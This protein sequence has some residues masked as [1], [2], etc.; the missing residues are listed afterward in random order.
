MRVIGLTGSI[1]CGKSTI[2][3]Y[4]VSCGFPVV[5]GDQLSRDL[6]AP[7]SPVLEEI[8][9]N[10]GDRFIN[11]NGNLNRRALGQL[12]FRDEHA[13]SR[14]DAVMAPHLKRL[15]TELIEHYR[16]EGAAL[17]F[18]D[19]PLLF[20]KGYDALCDVV[21]TVWL[22]EE[23]QLSRLMARDSFS[24][25]DALR[26]IRSVMS[27]DEKARRADH[28]ID[29]SGSVR[30]TLDE[31]DRLLEA[32]LN[33]A[34]AVE[35]PPVQPV[36]A[37]EPLRRSAPVPVPA[38]PRQPDVPP[39]APEVMER[40]AA[41]RRQ[42]SSRKAE[43]KNPLWMKISLIAASV[44]LA[45]S[46]AAYWM[47]SGYLASQEKKHADEQAAVD[48]YYHFADY[49]TTYRPIVE[50]YAA[51]FNLNPAFVCAVIR[52]ESSFRPGVSSGAS[53][54]GLMQLREGTASDRA[55]DLGIQDFTFDMVY[56]PE[57]NIRLGCCHLRYLI[58]RF[59][60]FPPTVISAYN[61]GEGTVKSWLAGSAAGSD[62][63][64]IVADRIPYDDTR[65]YVR[66][67]TEYYGVYQ[68]EFYSVAL[69]D[70][71]A[72]SGDRPAM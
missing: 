69:P 14:L 46:I 27:S 53:A 22:P 24:E 8:R 19:M 3:T 2:S 13:R 63:R 52:A 20:E 10:F 47:M 7:G 71:D 21:W 70:T 36:Q 40:P 6:T 33:P 16:S 44:L 48:A 30:N 60:D 64:T 54:R 35:P 72:A 59:G 68:K 55:R 5:D 49:E 23:L 32:E 34:V 1:A 37:Q 15:T 43:W 67:V 61:A 28:V 56:D 50:K 25:E 17:C 9:K 66:K 11:E 12:V 45:C 57:V 18:L 31:V 4:L 29:N 65:D 39:A 51:E 58:R 42:P 41:A 26:R 38:R 62:G